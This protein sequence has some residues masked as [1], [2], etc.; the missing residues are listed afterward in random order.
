MCFL[1]FPAGNPFHFR[2]AA[3]NTPKK[4]QPE[5]HPKMQ[6]RSPRGEQARQRVFDDEHLKLTFFFFPALV[7][8][9]LR[10]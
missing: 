3:Q 8:C 4:I 10:V 9:L 6:S 7:A 5:N 2:A 1:I